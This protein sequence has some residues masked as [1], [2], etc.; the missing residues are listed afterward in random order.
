[1]LWVLSKNAFVTPLPGT[2]GTPFF[3]NSCVMHF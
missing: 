1:M 2:E 3:V